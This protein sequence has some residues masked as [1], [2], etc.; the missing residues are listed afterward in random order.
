M[1]IQLEFKLE[2]KFEIELRLKILSTEFKSI[3]IYIQVPQLNLKI[4][5]PLTVRQR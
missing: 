2:I 1:E 5:T 3:A 4:G